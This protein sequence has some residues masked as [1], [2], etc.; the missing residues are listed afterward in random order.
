ME[1]RKELTKTQELAKVH[2]QRLKILKNSSKGYIGEDD[3]VF[4]WKTIS[5]LIE[6]EL[7]VYTDRGDIIPIPTSWY[8]LHKKAIRIYSDA[9]IYP[10]IK[11]RN[12]SSVRVFKG[13]E[14]FYV[15]RGYLK[16]IQALGVVEWVK[17]NDRSN[18]EV[19]TVTKVPGHLSEILNFLFFN[20]PEDMHDDFGERFVPYPHP[21]PEL[22]PVEENPS[23]PAISVIPS[24]TTNQSNG[25]GI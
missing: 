6:K 14:S 17:L 8:G 16:Q 15:D 3:R 1:K 11:M 5:V 12:S 10:I 13:H 25:K 20:G 4:N 22:A 7:A 21:A 18:I 24:T 2:L 23:S 19:L 9:L